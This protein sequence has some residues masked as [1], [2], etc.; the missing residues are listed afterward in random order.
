MPHDVDLIFCDNTNAAHSLSLLLLLVVVLFDGV[1]IIIIMRRQIQR[2]SAFL[3]LLCFSNAIRIAAIL[4]QH[5]PAARRSRAH[6]PSLK[7]KK[8]T[9]EAIATHH[10]Q[11]TLSQKVLSYTLLSGVVGYVAF[12]HRAVWLPLLDKERIQQTT[13]DLLQSVQPPPDA[14]RTAQWL[15][16][17]QYVVGMALWECIGLSTIPVETA[18]AMVWGWPGGALSCGGK[19][20]GASLAF[21]L[22]RTLLAQRIRQRVRQGNSAL[23]LLLS[24]HA[25]GT[26]PLHPPLVTAFYMKFSCFP[27]GIKN[28]GSACIP[29]LRYW[30]FLLVTLLHG[31]FFSGIWTWLGVD[32]AARLRDATLPTSGSLQAALAVALLIGV[33]LTPLLM[34]SWLRDLQRHASLPHTAGRRP[35]V[36]PRPGPA[37]RRPPILEHWSLAHLWSLAALMQFTASVVRT[38]AA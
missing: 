34:A 23:A 20:L 8:A 36:S 33:V 3:L 15:S 21:G 18:A 29:S 26:V 10:Q 11:R 24:S 13:L 12:Q 14:S 9:A 2:L 25:D 37:R 32:A 5:R 35:T 28:F 6:A 31:G 19:L 38:A 17:A 1:V 16:Y 7:V 30:M 4:Q 27:E 22:G